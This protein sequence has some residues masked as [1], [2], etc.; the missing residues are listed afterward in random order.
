MLSASSNKSFVQVLSI[1]IVVQGIVSDMDIDL[2]LVETVDTTYLM[3]DMRNGG[4]NKPTYF[5]IS[6]RL[7]TIQTS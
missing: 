5:S 6:M 1:S 3:G 2:E 7:H 4:F